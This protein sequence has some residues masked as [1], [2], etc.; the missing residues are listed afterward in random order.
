MK[1]AP[2]KMQEIIVADRRDGMTVRAISQALR[3]SESA[4]YRLFQKR[5]KTGSIEPSYQNCGK[6]SE[7]TAEELIEMNALVTENSDITL[8]E[9]KETMHLSIQKSEISNLLRNKL[10]FRYKKRRYLPV[11][12]TEQT[13]GK[14]E[15]CGKSDS[16]K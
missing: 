12:E 10:G 3:V 7:V 1:M 15:N 4:I 5:Q 9:I 8:A 11:N 2:M 6:E 16:W 13:Y 14:G